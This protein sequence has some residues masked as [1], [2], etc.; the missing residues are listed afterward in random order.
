M[1]T[2]YITWVKNLDD[3]LYGKEA[4]ELYHSSFSFA[5][6]GYND[7]IEEAFAKLMKKF[8]SRSPLYAMK[9]N[10]YRKPNSWGLPCLKEKIARKYGVGVDSVCIVNSA[11]SAIYLVCKALLKP[12]DL[13]V[14]EKPCYEPLVAAPESLGAEIDFFE[15][16]IGNDITETG[17]IDGSEEETS[18]YLEAIIS[19]VKKKPKLIILTNPYNP[20]GYLMTGEELTA[21]AA[22]VRA[23][24]SD[25]RIFIDEIYMDFVPAEKRFVSAS[26]QIF[27]GETVDNSNILTAFNLDDI[28]ITA[29]SLSKVYG[30]SKLGCGWI[31]AHS[32]IVE[33]LNEALIVVENSNAHLSEA[34][35]SIIFD[36]LEGITEE[37]MAEI[38]KNRTILEE[39][40]KPL[41]IGRKI[42]TG[43]IPEFGCIYFPRIVGVEDTEHLAEV[44]S[45]EPYKVYV[46]SGKFF[47][48]KEHIRIGYGVNGD[49]NREKLKTGLRNLVKGIEYYFE[50]FV[51]E[52]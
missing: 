3:R 35:G 15:R 10:D 31:I 51:E 28:F 39:E 33:K 29:N 2:E 46:T 30:L 24:N 18:I 14:V 9:S 44:L 11:S 38:I 6:E 17:E 27:S 19:A 25:T 48:A 20:G 16:K 40:L 36:R 26:Q 7:I 32:Q 13:V 1:R 42:I 37:I 8:N 47:G 22:A 23:E 4:F 45:E 52:K 41:R 12:G 49:K 5:Y 34:L 21:I 50:K 43:D